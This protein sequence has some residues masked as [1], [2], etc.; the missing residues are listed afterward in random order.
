MYNRPSARLK[1]LKR[2]EE[3]LLQENRFEDAEKVRAL[4]T[5][6]R[7][8]E[9]DVQ[10]RMM[11]HDYQES[12]AALKR[13]QRAELE[14]AEENMALEMER[15]RQKRAEMRQALELKRKLIENRVTAETEDRLHEVE[16][17]RRL[18]GRW[19]LERKHR[20]STCAIPPRRELSEADFLSLPP[21]MLDQEDLRTDSAHSKRRKRK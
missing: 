2:Q 10:A 19:K 5:D 20:G 4:I 17:V 13:K 18:D 1:L 8:N 7:A 16:K 9:K 12:L 14:N 11:Q 3:I 21:L 6:I 15:L